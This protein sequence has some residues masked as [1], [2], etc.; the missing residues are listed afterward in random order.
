MHY[1]HLCTVQLSS[2]CLVLQLWYSL[3]LLNS[4]FPFE[5]ILDLF[6]PFY[7]FHLLQ[8]V[9]HIV[10]PSG[11]GSSYWSSYW[12]SCEW[13]PF[14]YF[15]Y[16][17]S[18]RHSVYVSKPTQSLSINIIY[19]APVNV[20]TGKRNFYTAVSLC[21]GL[22]TRMSQSWPRPVRCWVVVVKVA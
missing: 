6:C 8:V 21:N 9:P 15:L 20:F 2:S 12:S 19:Y 5:A 4:S 22:S 7:K 17:T 13:F 14:V 11:L 10:F 18:F 1:I 16:N 3:G